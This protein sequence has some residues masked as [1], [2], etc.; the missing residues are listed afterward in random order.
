MVEDGSHTGLIYMYHSHVSVIINQYCI[1]KISNTLKL[2]LLA[3]VVS[4]ILSD[5]VMMTTWF[6]MT[7]FL[8]PLHPYFNFTHRLFSYSGSLPRPCI[9]HAFSTH[10]SRPG[11]SNVPSNVR[12]F[13]ICRKYPLESILW[14]R[15]TF[16]I[17]KILKILSGSYSFHS[18]ISIY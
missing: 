7:S 6:L 12:V 18:C 9:S 4:R 14:H 16:V 5:T 11:T 3:N 2:I 1:S 17:L 10:L 8:P 13:K 15:V